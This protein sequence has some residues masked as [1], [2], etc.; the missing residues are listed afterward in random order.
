MLITQRLLCQVPL[1]FHNGGMDPDGNLN[2]K[3]QSSLW[4]ISNYTLKFNL[5]YFFYHTM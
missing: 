5:N 3:I 2:L 1:Y 4:S